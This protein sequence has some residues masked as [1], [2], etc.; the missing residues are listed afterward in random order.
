MI[1]SLISLAFVAL[2]AAA[3]APTIAGG[4]G[5][6]VNLRQQTSVSVT[7]GSSVYARIGFPYAA[8]G[9]APES[10]VSAFVLP[11]GP[12]GSTQRV[13]SD[14]SFV[15]IRAPE[16]WVW[17][18]QTVM[19]EARVGRAPELVV[20]LRLSVPPAARPGGYSLAADLLARATGG[21]QRIDLVV[22]VAPR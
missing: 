9:L 18:L 21:R 22:Q 16:G 2:L 14:F 6:P 20:T 19:A 8:F 5:N 12:Q 17:E 3:C 11:L 4:A 10:F 13:T 1:R 15:D 7:A